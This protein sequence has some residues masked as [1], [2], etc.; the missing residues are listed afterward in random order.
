MDPQSRTVRAR[1]SFHAC[2]SSLRSPR[3]PKLWHELPTRQPAGRTHLLDWESFLPLNGSERPAWVAISTTG[4]LRLQ[5]QLRLRL[6]NGFRRWLWPVSLCSLLRAAVARDA[7]LRPTRNRDDRDRDRYPDDRRRR[8]REGT[9][10]AESGV[11]VCSSEVRAATRVDNGH[12]PTV[13]LRCV[14]AAREETNRERADGAAQGTAAT[15]PVSAQEYRGELFQQAQ[16]QYVVD[17]QIV[18]AR[19]RS[20]ARRLAA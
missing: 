2:Y 7:A 14:C 15:C 16:A 18:T 13:S 11:V 4:C 12:G 1:V 17:E 10:K 20:V 3:P 19:Q 5:L 8:N 6:L 9:T